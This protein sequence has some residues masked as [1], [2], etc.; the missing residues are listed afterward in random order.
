MCQVLGDVNKLT[1][2]GEFRINAGEKANTFTNIDEAV[3]GRKSQ[4]MTQ[5]TAS[6]MFLGGVAGGKSHGG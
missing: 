3:W 1:T 5:A 2:K 6:T 4:M